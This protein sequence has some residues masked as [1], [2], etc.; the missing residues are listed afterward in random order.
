MLLLLLFPLPFEL[1]PPDASVGV[2]LICDDFEPPLVA[3]VVEFVVLLFADDDVEFELLRVV[4]V[5][6]PDDF[7]LLRLDVEAEE[8]WCCSC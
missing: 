1:A 4:D 5:E 8:V 3:F 7:E 2:C 6:L